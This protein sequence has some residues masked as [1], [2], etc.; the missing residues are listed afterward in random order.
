M[1][2]TL[3]L[4][5]PETYLMPHNVETAFDRDA[6]WW[7]NNFHA[8]AMITSLQNRLTRQTVFLR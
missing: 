8:S 1:I 7:Q 3:V 6:S 4:N 2:S 5:V